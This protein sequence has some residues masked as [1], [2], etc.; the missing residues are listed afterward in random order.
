MFQ[1]VLDRLAE[2]AREFSLRGKQI[3][4]VG[5][6]VRN[7]L[8]GRSVKDYDFTT[9]ALPSEVQSY[10]RRV[11]PTGLQHGTVTVLFQGA[12]YEVT[13]FRIDGGYTDGRRPEGVT[14]TPSLEEDLKRRD[15]TINALALN[16]LDGTLVDPHD[17]QGD[18]AR[19]VL[20]AIGDPGQRF[21]EDALRMLRLFRF[22]SQLDFAIDPATLA[23]VGPRRERLKAVSK[24][25]I[26]EELVK[27]MDGARP[28]RAWSH[29]QRLN[30][31]TDLFNSLNPAAL[32]DQT[33][34]RLAASPQNLRWSLWLT[35]AC[36]RA[37][38]AWDACLR[39]LTFS[40]AERESCLGPAKALDFLEGPVTS[41]AAKAVLEAWGSRSRG[42]D[43]LT[44]LRALEAEG[45]L[46]D[47]RGLKDEIARA[48]ASGEPVFLAEL[49][50]GG[51]E[52]LAAGVK[53]G[54]EVGSVLRNLQ[55][56]V[57]AQ[58]EL[59]SAERLLDRVRHLR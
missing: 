33:L 31:L 6:A 49:A 23:A 26:R 3:Y 19:R 24:E 35:L 56:E 51:R 1:P 53:P 17:G 20:K 58:P 8:L 29:L 37:R 43:G 30:L 14:F 54:P 52:L 13:T 40:N 59:N 45:Y 4:L 47:E 5:G 15:F 11:L 46:R 12:S 18:L 39:S 41:I 21:D 28:D 42:A 7:L 2:F 44:Y 50:V 25:R 10:F 34:E 9:D 55:R 36:G 57:W 32:P 27:T 38:D 16:L 22:A 48:L